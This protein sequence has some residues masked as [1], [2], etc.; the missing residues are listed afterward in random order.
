MGKGQVT[1]FVIVGIIL[2]IIALLLAYLI[3]SFVDRDET[4]GTFDTE[5]IEFMITDCIKKTGSD[6]LDILGQNGN[7][8]E[9]P[10]LLK[11]QGTSYWI[12]KYANLEPVFNSS[13][14][15]YQEW[16]DK[17]FLECLEFDSFP[18]YEFDYSLAK[19]RIEYGAGEVIYDVKF[20]I[21]I[22]KDE[23]VKTLEQFT[24]VSNIRYRRVLEKARDVVNAHFIQSFDYLDALDLVKEE[25]FDIEYQV[26]D[27][28]NLVFTIT[29][30]DKIEY[31]DY[32]FKFATNLERSNLK[33]TA[34]I[35]KESLDFF[36]PYIVYSPDRMA[37]LTLNQ[38][39]KI[40]SKK[41]VD[42]N[43]I[44][45]WA[46][47]EEKVS[48]EV[49]NQLTHTDGKKDSSSK[50]SI[51]YILDYPIYNFEP[52]GTKFNPAQRLAIFWDH[53]KI[54]NQGMMGMLY[55]GEQSE[56][57]WRPLQTKVDYDNHFVYGDIDG[58]SQYTIVDCARQECKEASVT[59]KSVPSSMCMGWAMFMI[60]IIIMVIILI[61]LIILLF[62][63]LP[64]LIGGFVAALGAF[65]VAMANVLTWV[66][67]LTAI[68]GAVTAIVIIA[69]A[70]FEEGET[71]VAFIPTCD[72]IVDSACIGSSTLV[73]G[74]GNVGSET[75]P[76]D[77][78]VEVDAIAGEEMMITAIAKKCK[79]DAWK[80]YECEITCT[81][82]Y[83]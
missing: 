63:L 61:I 9:T 18:G 12:Y 33:R 16:F 69:G 24:V 52:N 31:R 22:T 67:T 71:S 68:A 25:N 76:K 79:K 21:N 74:D 19:A 39:V 7:Y 34:I 77:S 13:I 14:D 82:A 83:K 75:I 53:E 81:A 15:E 41:E 56:F 70:G 44:T 72:Q 8:I 37:V 29:E 73:K 26:I 1:L 27:K 11:Y 65:A 38:G 58:F 48:R 20:P 17:E 40:T 57:K 46:E 50:T 4:Q 59:G 42:I 28:D 78:A 43:N 45:V 62:F 6:G 47:Y 32:V 36:M 10:D 35:T 23:K 3:T 51:N 55:R 54:P 2:L 60:I 80:C 5:N 49:T 64:L 30:R 66:V